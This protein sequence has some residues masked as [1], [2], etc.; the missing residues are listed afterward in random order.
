MLSQHMSGHEVTGMV[1]GQKGHGWAG[2]REPKGQP[3]PQTRDR[4]STH[5]FRARPV[6]GPERQVALAPHWPSQQG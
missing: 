2:Y 6:H 3:A 5:V 1:Q 4:Q